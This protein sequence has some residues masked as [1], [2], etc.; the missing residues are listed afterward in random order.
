M[1]RMRLRHP[2]WNLVRRGLCPLISRSS[3]PSFRW[4]RAGGPGEDCLSSQHD[5]AV[6]H[7]PSRTVIATVLS[8]RDH[9]PR[10]FD[11]CLGEGEA[12]VGNGD[13]PRM[14]AQLGGEAEGDRVL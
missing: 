4:Y 8:C 5:W 6:D 7:L 11:V 10:P 14:N 3:K 2:R 9:L 12:L 1:R 13:L